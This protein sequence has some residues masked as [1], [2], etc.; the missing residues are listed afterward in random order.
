MVMC[1]VYGSSG[2]IC[3]NIKY[4]MLYTGNTGDICIYY[5]CHIWHIM[6]VMDNIVYTIM[7]YMVVYGSNG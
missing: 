4:I 6:V 7:E 5:M 2:I 1:T 3:I